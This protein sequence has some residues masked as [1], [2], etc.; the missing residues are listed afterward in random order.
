MVGF[1]GSSRECFR[2]VR[3]Q[4]ILITSGSESIA[5]VMF[6]GEKHSQQNTKLRFQAENSFSSRESL[7]KQNKSQYFLR[8]RRRYEHT[9]LASP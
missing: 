2:L 4:W 1:G 9:H 5:L 8:T 7:P 6:R 3:L